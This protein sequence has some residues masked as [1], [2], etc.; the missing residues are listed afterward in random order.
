MRAA[1]LGTLPLHHARLQLRRILLKSSNT[2]YFQ[3]ISMFLLQK[4]ICPSARYT[5]WTMASLWRPVQPICWSCTRTS[6]ICPSRLLMSSLQVYKRRESCFY[7][8]DVA[9]NTNIPQHNKLIVCKGENVHIGQCMYNIVQR[10]SNSPASLALY[11]PLLPILH[12][13]PP[14]SRGIQLTFIGAVLLGQVGS[15]EDFADGD[16]RVLSK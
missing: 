15:W 1:H 10:G 12:L 11:L 3:H 4:I 5:M 7:S 9:E 13:P 14:R 16:I 8:P 2:A 6:S